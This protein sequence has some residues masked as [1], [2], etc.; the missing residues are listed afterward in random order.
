MINDRDSK[1]NYS[2]KGTYNFELPYYVGTV[3]E[4]K[5]GRLARI[6]EYKVYENETFVGL[7]YNLYEM[8]EKATEYITLDELQNSWIKT[9]KVII[10][11][12]RKDS[13]TYMN[14]AKR[15]QEQYGYFGVND[16]CHITRIKKR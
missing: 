13:F 16:N 10:S 9:K 7:N 11:K 14:M 2:A 12:I 8:A 3:V 1:T 4:N 5:D 6:Y 15:F